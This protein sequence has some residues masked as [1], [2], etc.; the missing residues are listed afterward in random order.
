[1]GA[2]LGGGSADGAS[3]LRLLDS[4]FQ[5]T[6]TPERLAAYALQ[7]GSDCP[8][9]LYDQPCF[10]TGRGELLEPV[11]LDLSAWCIALVYPGI[12]IS[13][14]L[15]FSELNPGPAPACLT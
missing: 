4:T 9:F 11:D 12:H 5:L 10:A 15:A 8:F 7:L 14:A 6:I 2:G 1:M 13:T 3:M